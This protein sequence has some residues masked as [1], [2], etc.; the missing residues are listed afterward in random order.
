MTLLRIIWIL[1]MM[2]VVVVFVLLVTAVI[3]TS[4]SSSSSSSSLLSSRSLYYQRYKFYP[5]YCS[6]P[7]EM[8]TRKIPPLR[9]DYYVD[10]KNKNEDNNNNNNN[11]NSSNTENNNDDPSNNNNN[12]NNNNKRLIGE[13]RLVHVTAIIRHGARTPWSNEMKC[14]DGFWDSPDTG[15]WDCDDLT[16]FMTS[17]SRNGTTSTT[18]TKTMSSVDPAFFLFE[19]RYDAL[20]FPND[21]LT[22]VLNG[23]CQMGQLLQQG[24]DQQIQNG[25]LI[26]DAYTYKKDNYDHDERMRLLDISLE[27]YLPWDRDKL[28]FRADDDQRT[29]MSGQVLLRGLFEPELT[30][31]NNNNNS[32][33]PVVV[34]P[35]HIADRDKDI[36]DAND[37][38]CPKLDTIQDEARQSPEY[39]KFNNSQQSQ[40]VRQYMAE[41][42][43]IMDSNDASPMDCLMCTICTDRSLPNATNDYDSTNN[44][45]FSKLI[46]Y[47]IQQYTI[48]MKY[49]NAQWAKLALGPLWY[50]IMKNINPYINNE[51]D[52]TT[53]DDDND[54]IAAPRLALFAGHD[55]T[56][57]PLL[58][59]LGPNLWNDTDWASYASMILIEVR[60]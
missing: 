58:A 12:N 15:V 2:A 52:T 14:W 36:V 10:N 53:D 60:F 24:Y 46:E 57:M 27:D 56:L 8:T 55:T 40:D 26:R 42:M 54:N 18:K 4:S 3:P 50:E 43:G 32:I 48:P 9:D 45:W 37:N 25:K 6:T 39:Q 13:T 35:L 7:E 5:P 33:N 41:Q 44:N 28:Y 19:K 34:I 49:N 16:T 47:E 22:N 30:K 11:N 17:P 23:T 38:D 51:L 31:I 29:V 20:N 59:S 1:P 21:G